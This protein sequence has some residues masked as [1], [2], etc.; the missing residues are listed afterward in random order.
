[1]L[2][3]TTGLWPGLTDETHSSRGRADGRSTRCQDEKEMEGTLGG[4]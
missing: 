2:D 4:H 3:A 1:M